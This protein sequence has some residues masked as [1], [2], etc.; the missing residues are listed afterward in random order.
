VEIP[1]AYVDDLLEQAAAGTAIVVERVDGSPHLVFVRAQDKA[2]LIAA[3]PE[4]REFNF[5]QTQRREVVAGK[6]AG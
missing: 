2:D 3:R 6:P 1:S 4:L 5:V